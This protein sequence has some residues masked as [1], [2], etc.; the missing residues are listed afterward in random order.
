MTQT[1]QN[2]NIFSC[3]KIFRILNLYFISRFNVDFESQVQILNPTVCYFIVCHF[4]SD[5]YD[6]L[7]QF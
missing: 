2:Q 1:L 6:Q 7:S 4:L 3:I 5:L